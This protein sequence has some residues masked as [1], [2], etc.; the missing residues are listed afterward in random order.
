MEL[1]SENNV[2]E[3]SLELIFDQLKSIELQLNELK[4]NYA[5]DLVDNSE[6]IQLFKISSRTAQEW[7][8]KGVVGYSKIGGKVYY[9]RSEINE[10]IKKNYRKLAN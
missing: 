1:H 8:N 9:K 5:I 10:L 4:K 3:I 7:R 2:E 6:L